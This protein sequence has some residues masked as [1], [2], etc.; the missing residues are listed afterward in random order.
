[1]R[2][3]KKKLKFFFNSDFLSAVGHQLWHDIS[4]YTVPVK[5]GSAVYKYKLVI[6]L[7]IN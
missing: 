2:E 5:K 1:M 4:E 7:V 6:D 3:N